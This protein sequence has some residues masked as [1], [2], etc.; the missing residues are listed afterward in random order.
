MKNIPEV[1]L[2]PIVEGFSTRLRELRIA[3]GFLT[4]PAL[5]AAMGINVNT[6]S[7]HEAGRHQP[8]LDMVYRYATFLGTSVAYLQHAIPVPAAVACYL[9]SANTHGLL[10]VTRTRLLNVPWAMLGI[11]GEPSLNEVEAVAMVIDRTARRAS[12]A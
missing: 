12:K 3:A 2:P 9:A 8:T 7:R 10:P 6:I 5:A 4:Q 1:E 11:T